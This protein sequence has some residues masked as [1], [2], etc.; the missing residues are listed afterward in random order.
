[1]EYHTYGLGV[2]NMYGTDG[3]I[4][5]VLLKWGYRALWLMLYL[6]IAVVMGYWHVPITFSF[7]GASVSLLFPLLTSKKELFYPWDYSYLLYEDEEDS[8]E[9]DVHK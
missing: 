9:Y 3:P 4:I 2:V 8:L 7:I 6:T 5:F 1:M